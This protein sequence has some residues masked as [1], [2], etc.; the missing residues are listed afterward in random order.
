MLFLACPICK[1]KHCPDCLDP[2]VRKT[3]VTPYYKLKKKSSYYKAKKKS[4]ARLEAWK[5]NHKEMV[6]ERT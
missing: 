6:G 1:P 5:Q 3:T 2:V 4:L